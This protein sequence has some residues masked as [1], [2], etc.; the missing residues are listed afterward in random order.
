MVWPLVTTR[1]FIALG[2]NLGDREANLRRAL[3]LLAET[4]GIQVGQISSFIENPA[5][6]GPADSPAFLNAAAEVITTLSPRELLD[7]LL[8]IERSLGR[9]RNE[10]WSPRLI[11]LDVLLYGDAIVHEKDLSIP[12]PLMHERMFV[13]VP[14][15]EIAGDVVH[16]VLNVRV[17]ELLP[18]AGGR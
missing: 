18:R 6:G 13:L 10:K 11:D 14:L 1:A 9:V 17:D 4:P 5:V 12:H 3:T 15:A 2:A 16:P 8:E 7:R